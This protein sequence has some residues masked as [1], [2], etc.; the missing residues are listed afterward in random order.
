M[1]Y[2]FI[3]SFCLYFRMTTTV[4]CQMSL[5]NFPLDTN[6]CSITIQSFGYGSSDLQ[7]LWIKGKLFRI[8][9]PPGLGN[10]SSENMLRDRLNLDRLPDRDIQSRI[11]VRKAEQVF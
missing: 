2:R 8:K 9:D 10:M 6:N 3:G 1:P 5:F 7:L 11:I 4:A